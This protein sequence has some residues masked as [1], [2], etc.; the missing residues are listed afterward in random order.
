MSEF[1]R[2]SYLFVRETEWPAVLTMFV[3]M[4]VC[5]CVCVHVCVLCVCCVCACVRM[6]ALPRRCH[7]SPVSRVKVWAYIIV[8]LLALGR[9]TKFG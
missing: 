8:G 5:V 4:Y 1:R 6:C 7:S 3:C 2:L 9:I